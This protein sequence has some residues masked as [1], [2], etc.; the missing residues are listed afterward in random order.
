[1][2]YILVMVSYILVSWGVYEH[3]IQYNMIYELAMVIIY[4]GKLRCL[5]TFNSI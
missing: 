5:W 1:M 4:F 3:L 2:I